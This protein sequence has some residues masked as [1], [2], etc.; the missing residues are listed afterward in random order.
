MSSEKPY[1]VLLD[2]ADTLK[3]I[4]SGVQTEFDFKNVAHLDEALALINENKRVISGIIASAT[5]PEIKN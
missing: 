1:I 4:E 2:S 5:L 3:T